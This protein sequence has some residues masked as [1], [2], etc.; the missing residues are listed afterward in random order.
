MNKKEIISSILSAI[1]SAQLE[2]LEY[3]QLY[4]SKNVTT[5]DNEFLFFIKPEI[6]LN[7]PEIKLEGILEMVFK[8]LEMFNLSLSDIRIIGSK[9]LEKH[10]LIA[11]HYGVINAVSASPEKSLSDDARDRFKAITGKST[12]EV[13]L[14]GSMEVIRRFPGF[15][16]ASL[17]YLWQNTKTEKL[18]GGTYVAK[19]II[20]GHEIYILNGFHPRQLDHYTQA[21]RS[22]VSMIL[23][24]NISWK[25]AR[26]AFIGATNP[27]VALPGSLRNILLY[28]GEEFGLPAVS[29]GWNGFH[30]SAGPVEG[31]IELIRY[32]SDYSKNAICTP[33]DF[34]FGKMLAE[35]FNSDAMERILS[36]TKLDLEGKMTSIFDLTE[37]KNSGEAL[38][39]LKKYLLF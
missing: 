27:A 21:G 36:N 26:N 12:R 19:T 20:D 4:N 11:Q 9:Y 8:Q 23:S 7:S 30:L 35:H 1:H 28:R 16:P 2:K 10:N 5:G 29:S 25:E 3:K 32:T 37:E 13:L 17:D 31:L 18:A 14:L 33:R 6:T 39:I 34:T 24:G 22:I 15:T 38:N